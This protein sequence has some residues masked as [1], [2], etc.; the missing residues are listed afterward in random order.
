MKSLKYVHSAGIIHRDIKPA[1]VL[2]SEACELKVRYQIGIVCS[3]VL[4][5]QRKESA[6]EITAPRD[7][8]AC[9][10]REW[11]KLVFLCV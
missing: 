9:F 2:L 5:F 8:G 7:S 3:F 10:G 11:S 4:L 1:N 6:V